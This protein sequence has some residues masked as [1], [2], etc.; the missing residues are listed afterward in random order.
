MTR[1][2][3]RPVKKA[4]TNKSTRPDRSGPVAFAPRLA[5]VEPAVPEPGPEPEGGQT[6]LDS[7]SD[8]KPLAARGSLWSRLFWGALAFL[9]SLGLGLAA[10]RLI[11]DLFDRYEWLGWA[12]TIAAGVLVLALLVLIA[13]E[14]AA[15]ARLSRISH[16]RQL[17]RSAFGD[18]EI[19][20]A[21]HAT[22]QLGALI[23]HR[24]GLARAREKFARSSQGIFDGAELVGLAERELLGPL[25]GRAKA[26]IAASA[27]RVSLVTAVSP[28]ALID[29]AFVL[30][31]A[32]RLTGAIARLYGAKPGL[33]GGFRVSRAVLAH[34][35]VTGG[36][37]LTD[38]V[39]EQLLGQSLTSRLSRRLGEGLVNGLMTVRVGI[40]A[41]TVIRPFPFLSVKK[42]GVT[43]F[44]SE[45]ANLTAKPDRE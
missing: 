28:R 12:G 32:V 4:A 21:R 14:V 15:L 7:A 35:A 40:A 33:I 31:E 43:D 19:K 42:P 44:M 29:M 16:I 25:D 9:V 2:T 41:L 5:N 22:G 34:L 20:A 23:A 45:L 10:E 24:P 38:G 1:P 11:A 18:D 13:R 26:L 37:A 27:R 3:A 6:P 8:Q 36:V 30:F 39:L 17:A